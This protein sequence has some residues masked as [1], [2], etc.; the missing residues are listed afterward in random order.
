MPKKEEGLL[1]IKVG[2]DLVT[3]LVEKIPTPEGQEYLV[4]VLEKQMDGKSIP[5]YRAFSRCSQQE[6]E[7]HMLWLDWMASMVRGSEEN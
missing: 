6:Q 5:Q 7:A 1:L 2:K 4:G 3:D